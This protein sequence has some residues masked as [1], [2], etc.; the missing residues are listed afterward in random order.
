MSYSRHATAADKYGRASDGASH[1]LVRITVKSLAPRRVTVRRCRPAAARVP[2]ILHILYGVR[3]AVGVQRQGRSN[4]NGV[5][6]QSLIEKKA[7]WLGRRAAAGILMRKQT[8]YDGRIGA[9]DGKPG[10]SRQV[11]RSS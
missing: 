3:L 7:R 2:P 1:R 10:A 8:R 6:S 5:G 4:A 9:W 11:D